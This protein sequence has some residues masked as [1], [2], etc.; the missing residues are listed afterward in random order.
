MC[1]CAFNAKLNMKSRDHAIERTESEIHLAIF[2][3]KIILF[4]LYKNK[5]RDRS[6]DAKKMNDWDM[7]V[8]IQECFLMKQ[9]VIKHKSRR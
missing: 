3:L 8:I 5:V 4:F 1:T 9:C 2:F 7:G 6:C